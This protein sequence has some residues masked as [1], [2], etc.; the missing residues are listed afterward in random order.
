MKKLVVLFFILFSSFYSFAQ[1][2]EKRF[3]VMYDGGAWTP[4][5]VRIGLS[6]SLFVS[7]RSSDMLV[8]GENDI[9]RLNENGVVSPSNTIF[10]KSDAKT[11]SR[12]SIKL[13]YNKLFPIGDLGLDIGFYAA[14]GYEAAIE[15]LKYTDGNKDYWV[16]NQRERVEGIGTELG[17]KILFKNLILS[18]GF[19][20]IVNID[21]NSGGVAERKTTRNLM[22]TWS[23]GYCF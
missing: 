9:Y 7:L 10:P 8:F 15:R 6:N 23:V 4:F 13:G 3:F 5:G 19:S 16:S 14:L 20:Y 22:P 12:Y 11:Y 1:K 2:S 17:A 18:G 21:S